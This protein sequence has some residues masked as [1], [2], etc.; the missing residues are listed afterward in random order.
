[1]LSVC[2]ESVVEGGFEGVLVTPTLLVPRFT[3]STGFVALFL[4]K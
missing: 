1:M 3:G 2:Q 4:D